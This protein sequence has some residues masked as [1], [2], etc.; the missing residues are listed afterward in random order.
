VN[1]VLLVL[2]AL[3]VVSCTGAAAPRISPG[4]DLGD[5]A[6]LASVAAHSDARFVG[7]NRIDVLLDG[8][9]TFPRIL[10]AIRAA[11]RSITFAQYFYDEGPTPTTSRRRSRSA[12]G[13]ASR[14]TSSWTPS[15]AAGSRA[16]RWP[17]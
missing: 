6:F 14:R 4:L 7:G 3:A 9:G 2:A 17:P 8:D 11:R 13:R 5:R 16:R 1:R 15:A 12:A 10:A